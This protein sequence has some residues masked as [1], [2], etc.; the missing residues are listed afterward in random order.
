MRQSG[1]HIFRNVLLTLLLFAGEGGQA[2]PVQAAKD[3]RAQFDPAGLKK[4]DVDALVAKGWPGTKSDY[5]AAIREADEHVADI[6]ARQGYT[7][8]DLALLT[9]PWRRTKECIVLLREGRAMPEMK[10]AVRAQRNGVCD[11]GEVTVFKGDARR[12]IAILREIGLKDTANDKSWSKA[13]GFMDRIPTVLGQAPNGDIVLRGDLVLG[14]NKW[15]DFVYNQIYNLR[16]VERYAER[17]LGNGSY[18]VIQDVIRDDSAGAPPRGPTHFKRGPKPYR[19]IKEWVNLF[20]VHDNGDGTFTLGNFQCTHG[21]E[22]T[23]ISSGAKFLTTVFM[24]DLKKTMR[25]D[26]IASRKKWNSL[27]QEGVLAAP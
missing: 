14:V 19:P 18:V 3:W 7:E 22:L 2:Q 8:E 27:F 10:L 25:E 15:F 12:A 21:Q 11:C 6:R 17:D 23:P 24:V 13:G 5:A 1:I 20:V 16:D 9:S 4:V 26:T